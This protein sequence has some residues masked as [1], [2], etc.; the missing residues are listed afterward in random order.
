MKESSYFV[1]GLHLHEPRNRSVHGKVVLKERWSSAGLYLHEPRNRSVHG[2]VVLKERWSLAVYLHEPM[3]RSVHEKVV[4]KE[5][6]RAP[7]VQSTLIR[8]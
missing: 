4:L 8:I 5:L 6:M 3:N 1:G 7:Q 2:K